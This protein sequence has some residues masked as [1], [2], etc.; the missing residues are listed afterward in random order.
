MPNLLG[1]VW[2]DVL[3]Q[4]VHLQRTI[5][6]RDGF[7]VIICEV[8]MQHGVSWSPIRVIV[9]G[10]KWRPSP[11][12]A[13][14]WEKKIVV[15]HECILK[16]KIG[17]VGWIACT[18]VL[19]PVTHDYQ[20]RLMLPLNLAMLRVDEQAASASRIPQPVALP[21]ETFPP[22]WPLRTIKK[23][24]DVPKLRLRRDDI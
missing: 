20:I 3:K 7:I 24:S 9:S 16:I 6:N 23:M 2:I 1:V 11:V 13:L 14:C 22:Y 17:P 15:I 21:Y 19:Y 5:V 4:F 10:R 18:C 12:N 8:L